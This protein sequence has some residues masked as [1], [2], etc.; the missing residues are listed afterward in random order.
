MKNK[1]GKATHE[2]CKIDCDDCTHNENIIVT[3]QYTGGNF[4]QCVIAM[5]DRQNKLLEKLLKSIK[6]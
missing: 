2:T 5:L 1:C 3:Q 4:E 6:E